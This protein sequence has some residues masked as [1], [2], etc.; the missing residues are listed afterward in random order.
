MI[1]RAQA[2][3]F[4]IADLPREAVAG[5]PLVSGLEARTISRD[6]RSGACTL[7]IDVPAGFHAAADPDGRLDIFVLDGEV[8]LDGATL[9]G[10]GFATLPRGETVVSATGEGRTRAIVFWQP[11]GEA[12]PAGSAPHVASAWEGSWETNTQPGTPFGLMR[13][14]LREDDAGPPQG[15]PGGWVRLVH[16]VPGWCTEGEERHAGCWEENILLRGDVYMTDRG[17]AIRTG[18]CLANP[19]GHWHGPMATKGGAL[20]LVHCDNPMAVEL[21]DEGAHDDDLHRY[22]AQ[23]PWA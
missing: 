16:V 12:R 9:E 10:G 21:R 15:P 3:M 22:L 17:A 2:W 19:P 13:R 18:D 23:S 14:R 5:V 8:Q 7:E 20:F 1:D 11:D 4:A 6:T